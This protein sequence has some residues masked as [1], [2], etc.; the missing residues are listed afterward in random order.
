M[1]K[2]Y[3]FL[4][5]SLCVCIYAC[6]GNAN[7]QVSKDLS[8]DTESVMFFESDEVVNKLFADYNEISEVK[9]PAEEIQKG[10][11]RTKALVYMDEF[12]LEVINAPDF[13]SIS[14]GFS[15]ESNDNV[16]YAVFRDIIKVTR[17]D[18]TEDSIQSVWKELHE[19]RVIKEP[20]FGDVSISIYS[21][22]IDLKIPF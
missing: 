15:D 9:I 19:V 4:F 18:V 1:K 11:I 13:L 8:S 21:Q 6:G 20:V 10:N 14:I 16:L 22:R 7:T 5:L 17:T 2:I 12:S 3:I